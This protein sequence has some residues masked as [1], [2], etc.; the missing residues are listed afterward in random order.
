M[1]SIN[2]TEKFIEDRIER[3][4]QVGRDADALSFAFSQLR[5]Q[6]AEAVQ[7]GVNAVLS[8][9]AQQAPQAPQGPVGPAAPKKPFLVKPTLPLQ[10]PK[11]EEERAIAHFQSIMTQAA[12]PVEAPPQV[13]GRA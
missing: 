2:E 5:H 4:R 7:Q 12:G 10:V 1:S 9:I 6:Y 8:Q 11:E 3:L 13:G